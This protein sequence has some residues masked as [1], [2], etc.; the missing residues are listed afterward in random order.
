MIVGIELKFI[1][2]E[3]RINMRIETRTFQDELKL[4]NEMSK[5]KVKCKCSHVVFVFP[6]EEYKIC[7]HCGR[8]AIARELCYRHYQSWKRYGDALQSERNIEQRRA[9]KVE[10]YIRENGREVHKNIAEDMLGRKLERGEI[11]HHIDL[12]KRNNSK[13]NLY[14]CKDRREHNRC[15]YSL[16]QVGAELLKRGIIRFEDGKYR[17]N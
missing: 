3:R 9:N 7:K 14:I 10:P 11:V 1:K 12:D 8:K 16:E 2:K 17:I 6:N 5:F 4:F 15:H 13:S